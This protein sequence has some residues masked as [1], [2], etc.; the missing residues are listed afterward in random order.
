MEPDVRD[1]AVAI[2]RLVDEHQP[3][4]VECQFADADGRIHKFVEKIPLVTNADLWRDSE[5]PQPGIIRC[6]V[7]Q[8]WSDAQAKRLVRITTDRPWSVQS[9]EGLTEF[10]VGIAEL[11]QPDKP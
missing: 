6:E 3:G 5:Y 9:T 8:Q 4:W 11:A 1:L 7:L 2:L 10:V